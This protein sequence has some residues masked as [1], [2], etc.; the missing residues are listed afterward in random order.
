M[1]LEMNLQKRFIEAKSY[2]Q[3]LTYFIINLGII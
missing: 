1:S 3:D 2:K